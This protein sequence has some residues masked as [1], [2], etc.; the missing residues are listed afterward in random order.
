MR[1]G[2]SAA[3]FLRKGGIPLGLHK[4]L[5]SEE[6]HAR[7]TRTP[8]PR[9]IT[10]MALPTTASQLVSVVYNTADTYFVAQ[11]G[12]SAAAAVGVVFSL[13][14]LIQA[15]GFGIGMGA[16]SLIS[17]RLGA[18]QDDEAS[19][20]GSSA[21]FAA[22]L[23]GFLLGAAGLLTIRPLM[24]L[25]GS[26]TTMLPYSCAYARYILLGAPI[27]CSSF[28]LNNILRS[29]GEAVLSM[30]GLCS[31]GLLN[32]AL[33][34][35]FIFTFR[36]GIA[37]AALATVLSQCVS[38]CILLSAFVRNKSIV[39]LRWR[40]VSRRGADYLLILRMGF[41]TIC[42]QGMAS[43]S[44]ALLNRQAALYG[45]AA[46]AAITIANKIYLLV[47]NMVIG[48]GQGFQPVAG[49]N[50]GAGDKRRVRQA[51]RFSVELGTAVCL[52]AAGLIAWK[53]GL[54]IGWFRRDA[55]VIRIGT[56]ALY[57]GCAVMPVMAYS[58]YVN[59]LY[60]CLG[61]SAPATFLASCRQG[62]FF[63]P[64]ILILPHV[65][66]LAGVQMTQPA[67]D[68]LTFLISV[69]FQIAFY[70]KVLRLDGAPKQVPAS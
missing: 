55:E 38:F 70:R 22:V 29:E 57:F 51:F 46:V 52:I 7:M 2:I 9:L 17:R 27:M 26:T 44:S 62:I 64:L 32:V 10:A 16:N 31:G 14:S 42:R 58:T 47:R 15:A 53:A 61:F 36:M 5:S 45:D 54:I 18:R 41:P 33:D 13:M 21:F 59:Q 8:I 24:R 67:S 11:I 37:G 56:K 68:A 69:P 4:T 43:L 63:V 25:L 34:P 1:R 66:G 23:V 6:Q 40:A 35:L 65:L 12:N 48:I 60:Q 20:Y 50:Y 28:V 3:V 49:Y 30:W 39:K 19:R